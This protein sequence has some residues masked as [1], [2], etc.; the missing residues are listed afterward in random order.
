MAAVHF[1]TTPCKPNRVYK[2]QT[3]AI[4]YRTILVPV[5]RTMSRLGLKTFLTFLHVFL[6]VVK[7]FCVLRTKCTNYKWKC[8]NCHLFS[9][10][11]DC[12]IQGLRATLLQVD[13]ISVQL[14]MENSS[15]EAKHYPVGI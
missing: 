1:T 9:L 11:E 7:G 6:N 5:L 4:C 14:L 15:L 2:A 13:I 8:T 10:T 12:L 3:K